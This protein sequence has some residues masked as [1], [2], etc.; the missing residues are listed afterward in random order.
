MNIFDIKGPEFLMLYTVSTVG[1]LIAATVASKAL[2]TSGR[3]PATMVSPLDEYEL[4]VLSGGCQN[5]FFAAIASLTHRGIAKLNSYDGRIT[6]IAEAKDLR[7]VERD[8]Y[9]KLAST[10]Q[11]LR[12]LYGQVKGAIGRIE[13]RLAAQRLLVPDDQ[14]GVLRAVS[15]LIALSP[16]FFLGLPKV[17]LGAER[18][19]PIAFLLILMVVTLASSLFF[20][21][22]KRRRTREGDQ[23]IEHA[24][25]SN[26]ALKVNYAAAPSTLSPHDLALGAALFG[27]G[28]MLTDPY[29]QA[30]AAVAGGNSSGSS[31]CSSSGCG[32]SSCGGG[33]CGGGGCGGCGG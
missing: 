26:S 9:E 16:L 1:A 25:I 32:S 2:A 28:A 4:A 12:W 21:F 17:I 10:P 3:E 23:V 30:R 24:K 14:L 18:G 6:R 19:K 27:T 29:Q 31:G 8:V 15:T 22:Q 5:A 20:A 13:T 7:S 33:G 11:S